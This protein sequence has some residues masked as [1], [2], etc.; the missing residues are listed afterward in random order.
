MTGLGT[1]RTCGHCSL[2]S[3]SLIGHSGSSAFRLSTTTVSMSLTGSR[4]SSD[5]AP[6]ALPSWDSKTRWNNLSGDLA[7]NGRQV[8][9]DI[10]THLIHRPARDIIPPLGGSQVFSYLNW[11]Y[12]VS[13]CGDLPG[14][15]EFAAIDPDAMHDHGQPTRQ[16]NDR[17]L[18]SAVP[19]NLHRPGFE[20][21]PFL[22][23]QHALSSG[24]HMLNASFSHVDPKRRLL[25]RSCGVYVIKAL[26]GLRD[27]VGERGVG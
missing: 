20:P 19:G 25:V 16:G 2:M 11:S 12:T 21:G 5:S 10:R 14:P 3:A 18:H 23:P 26:A 15:S 6:R 22:R 27:K 7:V 13:R 4:F 9:A 1:S 24:Q 17:L 8:Q